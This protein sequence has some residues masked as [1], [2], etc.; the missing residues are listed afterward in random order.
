MLTNQHNQ[1]LD[2]ASFAG[3]TA[4]LVPFLTLCSDI[5]PLTTGN[6]L[7]VERSLRA[8]HAANDVA[9]VELSVDTRRDTPARL[10]AY[11]NLTGLTWQ[12]VTETPS[13]LTELSKFFG[14][15]Y[16]YV[17]Q[18]NPPAV[19]W[20]TGRPLTYDENHSDG[21]VIIDPAGHE[22]FFTAA[23]PN[24]HG[25]LN[26]TLKKFLTDLGRQHLAHPPNPNYTPADILAA[27]GWSMHRT[28]APPGS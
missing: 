25:K 17:P 5:C 19:D 23:A 15:Y 22:R 27:L 9:I 2:L 21:Y 10:A 1:T 18:D 14:F 11:A 3:K 26:P 13:E 6:L 8:D 12:L 24:F 28:L 20:W 4:L 7:Q 16:Q